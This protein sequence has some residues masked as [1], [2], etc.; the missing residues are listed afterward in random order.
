M[1]LLVGVAA[2]VYCRVGRLG[3]TLDD[4]EH[5]MNNFW[6]S[7]VR[8]LGDLARPARYFVFSGE[9][10]YRPV[11]TLS[12]FLDRA[13]FAPWHPAALPYHMMNLALHL[14]NVALVYALARYTLPRLWPAALAAAVF[15]V[16]PVNVEVVAVIT[17]RDDSVALLLSLVAFIF[18]VRGER[19]GRVLRHNVLAAAFYLL[20]AFA[21]EQ[22]AMLPLAMAAWLVLLRPGGDSPRKISLVA[23]LPI[24]SA[25]VLFFAVRFGLVFSPLAARAAE[26]QFP[27][28]VRLV[29]ASRVIAE[30]ILR[31]VLPFRLSAMYPVLEWQRGWMSAATALSWLFVTVVVAVGIW[32]HRRSPAASF[33]MAWFFVQALP[34]ANVVAILNFGASDRYLYGAT[35]GWAFVL[36]E[37]AHRAA[38]GGTTV[39]VRPRLAAVVCLTGAAIGLL[40]IAAAHRVE[41][42]DDTVRCWQRTVSMAPRSDYVRCGLGSAYLEAWS[43]RGVGDPYRVTRQFQR[44]LEIEPR[45]A[46]AHLWLGRFFLQTNR[47]EAAAEHLEDCIAIR[48]NA[49]A[50]HLLAEAYGQSGRMEQAIRCAY[51]AIELQPTVP[52]VYDL[53]ARL[54][55]SAAGS[56]LRDPSTVVHAASVAC[57]LTQGRHTRFL[58]TLARA[59]AAAGQTEQA[60]QTLQRVLDREPANEEARTLMESL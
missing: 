12:Y 23:Y 56:A 9:V 28:A 40:S 2:L 13:L 25:F 42:W 51:R 6:L 7:D 60:R 34:V 44:A 50:Y 22:A 35:V 36:A 43:E 27:F 29:T 14:V 15:A 3:L 31:T 20:A 41:Q 39:A 5:L 48:E 46:L 45:S 30:Y 52:A 1:A 59:H 4:R 11:L 58:L 47:P 8:N 16:H 10:G 21:K 33:G 19:T 53:L 37:I 49:P 24:V 18:F 32:L 54:L 26:F 17:F 55:L 57:D 38:V